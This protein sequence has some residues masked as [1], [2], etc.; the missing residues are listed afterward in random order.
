MTLVC[1]MVACARD[2]AYYASI[3]I[4]AFKCPLC[5]KLCWHNWRKPNHNATVKISLGEK[6]C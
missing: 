2:L 1:C 5:S 4:N 3:M 6:K